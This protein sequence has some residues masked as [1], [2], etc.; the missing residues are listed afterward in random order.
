MKSISL[1]LYSGQ[2]PS[3]ISEFYSLQQVRLDTSN[4]F[5]YNLQCHETVSRVSLCD[6]RPV[7]P[8]GSIFG[9][10]YYYVYIK[11]YLSESETL[12]ERNIFV[13]PTEGDIMLYRDTEDGSYLSAGRSRGRKY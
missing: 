2:V 11:T 12:E 6:I 10:T 13:S 4:Y 1:Q 3:K 9:T 7:T 5:G 8:S